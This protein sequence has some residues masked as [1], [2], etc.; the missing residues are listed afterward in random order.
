MAE[1]E[2]RPNPAEGQLPD[3]ELDALG[4][5]AGAA[6]RVP[7]S[8][9]RIADLLRRGRAARTRRKAAAAG[10]GVAVAMAIAA[11]AWTGG[12]NESRVIS[13]PDTTQVTAPTP[14]E[15]AP[16]S[17]PLQALADASLLIAAD[18]G[19][20]W[21]LV[22]PPQHFLDPAIA[23][24]VDE[25][26]PTDELFR[27]TGEGRLAVR[28]FER[29]E[30]W[31]NQYIVAFPVEARAQ[32]AFS[33]LLGWSTGS[34][35]AG[36]FEALRD[37]L[38]L[39]AVVLELLGIDVRPQMGGGGRFT[40]Q[41]VIDGELRL[42]ASDAVALQ[43]QA[44][45]LY[46]TE[47]HGETPWTLAN[48][49]HDRVS[50]ALGDLDPGDS[51]GLVTG[52]GTTIERDWSLPDDPAG[53]S[54]SSDGSRL[55]VRGETEISLFDV[56]SGR[57]IHRTTVAGDALATV[58]NDGNVIF[59]GTSLVDGGTGEL[60]SA[61]ASDEPLRGLTIDPTGT[62]FVATPEERW[63]PTVYD[64]ASGRLLY[65]VPMDS[66]PALRS[67]GLA[68][69]SS[70]R[71][72]YVYRDSVIRVFELASGEQLASYAGATDLFTV[73]SASDDGQM[74]VESVEGCRLVST[75][76]GEVTLSVSPSVPGEAPTAT[77]YEGDCEM[78]HATYADTGIGQRLFDATTRVEIIGSPEAS[79]ISVSPD[80]RRVVMIA[81]GIATVHDILSGTVI[82]TLDARFDNDVYAFFSSDGD[83]LLTLGSM[84]GGTVWHLGP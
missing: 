32:T 79:T 77:Y 46:V 64:V 2:D 44:R 38:G 45:V 54:L 24:Q 39:S 49:A 62:W 58:D 83:T 43:R 76:T 42:D 67:D 18:L 27:R 74:V 7:A 71:L 82:A 36:C 50:R 35:R 65:R 34:R 60:I 84:G 12:G 33:D 19:D 59:D 53:V 80:G 69:S 55:I 30:A 25:C 52:G 16:S 70:G 9:E 29:G 41:Q 14:T 17:D 72:L 20:G 78:I 8:E 63:E 28:R 40:Y 26:D 3:D 51:T 5:R 15:P 23:A 81:D 11:L 61:P 31:V 1:V 73:R 6:L 10:G 66:T 13:V 56:E 68:L 4:R 21:E 37:R 47:S 57:E 48:V 75:T 22:E